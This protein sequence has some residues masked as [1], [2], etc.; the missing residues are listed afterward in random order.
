MPFIQKLKEKRQTS[1]QQ[2]QA[3]DA[4][5]LYYGYYSTSNDKG[6]LFKNNEKE[7]SSKKESPG[8]SN[9]S[10]VP[11]YH[12]LNKETKIGQISGDFFFLLRYVGLK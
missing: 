7:I 1:H 12:D 9:V 2:K 5:S 10:C 11:A 6:S 8:R 3:V 4:I